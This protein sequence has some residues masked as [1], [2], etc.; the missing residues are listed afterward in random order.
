MT[1]DLTISTPWVS[2]GVLARQ[3]LAEAQLRTEFPE[4]GGLR[5]GVDS[6]D[7]KLRPILEPGRLIVVAGASGS[8]KSAFA[9][10]L[11][12]A[13]AHQAPV[14]WAS[15]EDD[16]VDAVRRAIANVGRTSVGALRS[17]YRTG[18][19]PKAAHDAVEAI[20]A[21]PLDVIEATGDAISLAFTARQWVE[22]HGLRDRPMGGVLIVDQ[23]SH[24]AP[25]NP[26]RELEDYLGRQGLPVPPRLRDGDVKH[27][28]WQVNVLREVGRRLN[29]LVVVLHQL[30]GVRGDDG[31]PSMASVRGSQGIVHKADALLVPW[32]PTH[33]PNPFAGPGEPKMVTAPESAAELLCLKGRSIA[34]GWTLPLAWDGVHQ[35]LADATEDIEKP[36][37]YGVPQ[38]PTDS[39]LEG[40]KRLADLRAG[41]MARRAESIEAGT[42][43]TMGE[44][45]A[46]A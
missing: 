32:R 10:Q 36:V 38:A 18:V 7:E 26:T 31:R 3:A 23:L 24:I 4:V 35:R 46:S 27:L 25:S 45:P 17:G 22:A 41:F 9:S 16:G 34:S 6:I 44:L 20:D 11:A 2:A 21:L 37:P 14:L 42:S 8:G 13:F 30:N 40:A 43:P 5:T 19:V 12:V 15:L 33:V 39:Q 1:D 29:L 28:E